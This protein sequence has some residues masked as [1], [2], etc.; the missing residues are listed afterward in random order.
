VQEHRIAVSKPAPAALRI[1]VVDR[2]R[3]IE[4]D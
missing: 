4:S 2:F 3:N 1:V